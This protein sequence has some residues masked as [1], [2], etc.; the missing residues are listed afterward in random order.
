MSA[1]HPLDW[2]E[3]LF[4][5]LIGAPTDARVTSPDASFA[6]GTQKGKVRAENQDR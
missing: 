1:L 3:I 2:Q 5:N 6:F 4:P